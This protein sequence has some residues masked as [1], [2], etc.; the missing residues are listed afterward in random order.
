M[1]EIDRKSQFLQILK[2]DTM[3]VASYFKDDL[4]LGEWHIHPDAINERAKAFP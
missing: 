2:Q 1:E 4:D 3:I